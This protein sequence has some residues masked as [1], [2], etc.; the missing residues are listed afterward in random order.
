MGKV[1]LQILQELT[2]NS[3]TP[4]SRLA[5]EIDVSPRTVQKR[6]ERM[7]EEGIILRPTIELDLSRIGYQGKLI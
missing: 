1:D 5:K 4:F 6:Y 7:K 2:K 3:Q